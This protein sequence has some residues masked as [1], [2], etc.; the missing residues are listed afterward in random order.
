[1]ADT[2]F[3]LTRKAIQHLLYYHCILLLDIFQFSAI[4]APTPEIY[5]FLTDE[6]MQEECCRYVATPDEGGDVSVRP[7][8]QQRKRSPARSPERDILSPS[9]PSSS[10]SKPASIPQ[11]ARPTTGDL[12]TAT[13]PTYSHIAPTPDTVLTLYTSLKQGLTVKN[14]CIE[15]QRLL[16]SIDV[17]RFITFGVI[18]GFL[19]R[20]H[21]YAVA[22]QVP[23]PPK[24]SKKSA[25]EPEGER[26]WNGSGKKEREREKE[27]EQDAFRKAAT[28]SGWATP[29]EGQSGI[30]AGLRSLSLR[31]NAELSR[32]DGGS[33]GER[34]EYAESVD[35]RSPGSPKKSVRELLPL[36]RYLD[37]MHCFDEICS[38]L[39]MSERE[40]LGKLRGYG[41]VFVIHR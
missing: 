41:E 32:V 21:K 40:M 22:A 24:V 23:T 37:G 8:Q 18:K 5:V 15:N 12:S 19:Y 3:A 33:T 36:A 11:T 35:P 38:E 9:T 26:T 30:A 14:W 20:V 25:R 34:Q 1:M 31:Q 2:D 16:A 27:N 10:L 4:Y 39:G 28:S 17:R 29:R 7:A 6:S 13:V